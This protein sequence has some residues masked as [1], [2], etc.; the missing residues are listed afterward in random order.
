MLA[1]MKNREGL[2]S[3]FYEMGSDDFIVVDCKVWH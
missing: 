1:D 2:Q 3:F